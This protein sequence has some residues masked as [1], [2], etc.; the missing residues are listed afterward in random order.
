MVDN[1]ERCRGT[2]RVD[3]ASRLGFGARRGNVGGQ[4]LPILNIG[5][6]GKD[7]VAS[8]VRPMVATQRGMGEWS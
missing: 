1:E 3:R 6:Q 2:Y 5:G 7:G 8:S 4:T